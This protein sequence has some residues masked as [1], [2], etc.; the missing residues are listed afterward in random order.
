[1][2]DLIRKKAGHWAVKALMIVLAISFFIGFGILMSVRSCKGE[3]EKNYAAIVN[4]QVIS[5][6]EY[7]TAY[8][9]YLERYRNMLGDSYDPK[10][11]EQLNLPRQVLDALIREKLMAA[12]ADRLG[13]TV[14]DDYL[15]ERI[16][17]NKVFLDAQGRFDIRRYKE[18]LSANHYSAT[19]FE[20]EEKQRLIT[21]SLMGMIQDSIVITPEEVRN[22]FVRKNEKVKLALLMFQPSEL[23]GGIRVSD[24]EVQQHYDLHRDEFKEPAKRK[25]RYVTFNPHAFEQSVKVSPEDAKAEY[26]LNIGDYTFK[27]RV[28]ASHILFKVARNAD[29]DTAQQT[30]EKAQRVLERIKAGEDFATLAAE[31]GEDGT[32]SKGGDL[33]YFERGKM[34]TPFE[35]AAFAA[36]PGTLIDELVQTLFGYHIIKVVEHE[37]A[38]QTPFEEVKQQL[39]DKVRM[40]KS[41]LAAREEAERVL[42]LLREGKDLTTVLQN[43]N[44]TWKTSDFFS[45]T[46]QPEGIDSAR[47]FVAAAFGLEGENLSEIVTAGDNLYILQLAEEKPAEVPLLTSIRDKVKAKVAELKAQ[48]KAKELSMKAREKMRQGQDP[49]RVAEELNAEIII[50]DLLTIKDKSIPEVPDSEKL[51]IAALSAPQ[52]APVLDDDFDL[53]G[54]I[55]AVAIVQRERAD[56]NQLELERDIIVGQ[57]KSER[58]QPLIQQWQENLRMKADIEVNEG[59]FATGDEKKAP[60][61]TPY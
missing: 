9:R 59:I 4:D 6:S 49:Q 5:I 16:A 32:A 46:G 41:R 3:V 53:R 18:L 52:D 40:R 45:R 43:I 50:T 48:D 31:F 13:M 38:G 23:I 57:L 15:A 42:P 11:V 36:E 19:D 58:S 51:L 27:E 39:T 56:L 28:R 55:A 1:M 10:I 30:K 25:V 17:K 54:K 20:R 2:L 22:E 24:A 60:V 12:E 21:E 61:P 47:S 26:D 44:L 29:T 7:R 8:S 37:Q 34:V 33:G 14:S 35:D